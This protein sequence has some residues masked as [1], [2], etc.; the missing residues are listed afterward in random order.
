MMFVKFDHSTVKDTV[1]P[2]MSI[3]LFIFLFYNTICLFCITFE[4]QEI[5]IISDVVFRIILSG[6]KLQSK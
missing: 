5:A 4:S 2:W 3:D 1:Q 6:S